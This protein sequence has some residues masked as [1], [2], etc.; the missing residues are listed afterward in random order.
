MNNIGRRIIKSGVISWAV[1]FVVWG[2]I[3]LAYTES[4]FP[5]PVETFTGFKEILLNGKLWRI[6]V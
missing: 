6:S 4:F 2:L 1:L 5:S 3:S